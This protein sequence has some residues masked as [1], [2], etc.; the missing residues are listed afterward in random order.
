M[1]CSPRGGSLLR[2]RLFISSAAALLLLLLLLSVRIPVGGASTGRSASP[3]TV[4][5]GQS[6]RSWPT[7]LAARRWRPSPAWLRAALCIHSH[8]SVDWHR[9]GVD[10]RG[11]P[12]PYFGGMQFLVSTWTSAGG[13]GLPSAWSSRE[14][15]YRAWVVVTR[16]GGWREWG[17]HSACGV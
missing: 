11:M 5:G 3:S 9:A 1:P 7:S 17:T 15:L 14:Q 12:S 13:V 8:E 16:D 4:V 10:W 6:F 2:F